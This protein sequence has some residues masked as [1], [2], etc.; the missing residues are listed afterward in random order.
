[1]KLNSI[2]GRKVIVKNK[3]GYYIMTKGTVHQGDVTIL[4]IH[5]Q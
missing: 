2:E 5:T 3:D 1:M 4:S